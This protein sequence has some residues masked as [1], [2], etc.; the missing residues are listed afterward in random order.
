MKNMYPLSNQMLHDWPRR[1]IQRA[2]RA[3]RP[4]SKNCNCGTSTV[5]LTTPMTS[6]ID[7]HVDNLVQE[8]DQPHFAESAEAHRLSLERLLRPERFVWKRYKGSSAATCDFPSNQETTCSTCPTT[9]LV[10][11]G[12]GTI[13]SPTRGKLNLSRPLMNATLPTVQT[14]PS[15]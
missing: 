6:T 8:L 13:T 5:S 4:L 10:I 7:G 12:A 11:W 2:A 14:Q 3:Q 15:R 1:K 9:P